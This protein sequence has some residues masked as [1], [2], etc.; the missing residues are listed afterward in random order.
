M[1]AVAGV[2]SA[3]PAHPNILLLTV[4][5]LKP[6]LG[7]YGYKAV[8]SPNIDRLAAMGTVMMNNY[9]QQAICAPSRIS[10]FTGLRPDST[11]VWDLRTLMRDVNPDVV[12]LPQFFKNHGYETAGLGKLLH[13]AKNNDPVSWTVPY[14]YDKFLKYATSYGYPANGFY[15]ADSV[16]KV[17][18]EIKD[19]KMSWKAQRDY[20]KSHN[21]SPATECLDVPDAAYADGAIADEG[22]RL[23]AKFANSGKPFFLALGFHRPHLP[24]V[25]PKKYW[26]MYDESKIDLAPFRKH[27][28]GSPDFAYHNSPELRGYS[29]IP[30]EGPFSEKLQKHLIHGYYASISYTDAQIGKVMNKLKELGLTKNTIIVLWGDHGWHLGDHALWCK[31]TNFEQATRAPLIIAAPGYKA[32]QKSSAITEF[33]DI[34]PTLCQLAGFKVPEKL[35]GKSLVPVLENPDTDFKKF[36]VSQY[37]RENNKMG[38][39]LRTKR[40]RLVMW[41]KWSK[42]KGVLDRTPVAI[43]LYDY[44]KD[45]LETAN[46]ADNPEYSGT[47][48]KLSSMLTDF[49]WKKQN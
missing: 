24:F 16:K 23:L 31:Q 8:H 45:P 10:M 39:A 32:G 37:P 12:T 27:A 17:W 6:D 36:A 13:G 42:K 18:A 46:L 28:A 40:F 30:N 35:E 7:C 2:A 19:K 34:Y 1:A 11:K 41:F 5:D 44:D 43:E 4:D 49:L 38:Y 3:E 14:K 48:K 21:A 33:V 22:M 47:L 29:D 15:L 20:M 9:C 26:D 25:A